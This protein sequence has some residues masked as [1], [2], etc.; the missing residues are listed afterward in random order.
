ME[1]VNMFICTWFW[2]A[3]NLRQ[4]LIRKFLS[5][6]RIKNCEKEKSRERRRRRKREINKFSYNGLEIL[7]WLSAKLSP[8]K[9][10]MNGK[11]F[12]IV[13]VRFSLVLF[14]RFSK[15]KQNITLTLYSRKTER[16][17]WSTVLKQV[18]NWLRRWKR[19]ILILS[20][21]C[22]DFI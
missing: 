21:I 14:D 8:H 18:N 22:W 6:K 1:S 2:T 16:S 10:E 20:H 3:E 15:S 11:S 4:Y 19:T 13:C 5:D 9:Y 7:C 17:K 12:S